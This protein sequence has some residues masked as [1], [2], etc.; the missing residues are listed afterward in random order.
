MNIFAVDEDP[1]IAAQSLHDVHVNKMLVE[2]CQLL[3]TAHPDGSSPYAHTHYN[4]PCAVWVRASNANYMWLACHA[5]ALSAERSAR[6]PQR[7]EHAS[8]TAAIWY[9]T[10]VP[11]LPSCGL[12]RFAIAVPTELRC[13]DPIT[14]YRAYY[15][16]HKLRMKRGTVRWTLRR[17]PE[18]IYDCLLGSN[19]DMCIAY[20]NGRYEVTPQRS[21]VTAT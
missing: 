12:T 21:G 1:E 15:V 17:P 14:S 5:L 3:A 19:S 13:D 8:T 2:S 11:T 6:W 16:M 9:A 7:A 10:N 4:H 20:D 18:W